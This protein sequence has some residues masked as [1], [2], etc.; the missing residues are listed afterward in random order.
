MPEVSEYQPAP[1]VSK[2]A[3]ERT[4]VRDSLTLDTTAQA[5]PIITPVSGLSPSSV[6][7]PSAHDTSVTTASADDSYVVTRVTTHTTTTNTVAG[8]VTT[9][10]QDTVT[11][12]LKHVQQLDDEINKVVNELEREAQL[13]LGASTP[14]ADRERLKEANNNFKEKEKQK[15]EEIVA[16]STIA[17]V[18]ATPSIA[19]AKPAAASGSPISEPNKPVVSPV[20]Q[21]ARRQGG[22]VARAL[23][24]TVLSGLMFTILLIGTI[25][26]IME[27][28]DPQFRQYLR[29]VPGEDAFRHQYYE[30]TRQRALDWYQGVSGRRM[31]MEYSE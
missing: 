12:S 23:I 7:G 27:I 16:K 25:I 22:G 19:P 20:V 17:S 24:K 2:E 30:P 4:T 8:G 13:P 3:P 18:S 15:F 28:Q 10:K 1:V 26:V 5:T 6:N 9:Y 29:H 11:V 14:V 21:P 31:E